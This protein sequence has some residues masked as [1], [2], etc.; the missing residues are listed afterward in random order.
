VLEDNL[1]HAGSSQER[2]DCRPTIESK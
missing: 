1:T 2:R